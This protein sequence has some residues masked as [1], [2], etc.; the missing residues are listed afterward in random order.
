MAAKASQRGR[1]DRDQRSAGRQRLGLILFGALFALLFIGFAVAQGLGSPSVPSGDVVLVEDVPEE[2]GSISQEEFDK[3]L[4]QQAS[5]SKLKKVP[6]PGDD[7]YEELRDKTLEELV[8]AAKKSGFES[9]MNDETVTGEPQ[10]KP[11]TATTVGPFSWLR[12][13]SAFR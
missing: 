1:S 11:L 2:I 13:S 5:A 7:K 10:G 9:V 6:K 8:N 3:A 12:R 4:V